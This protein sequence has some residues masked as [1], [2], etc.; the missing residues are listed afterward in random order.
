MSKR[1]EIASSG[2]DESLQGFSSDPYGSNPPTSYAL[3]VPPAIDTSVLGNAQQPR[4]WFCLATRT[5]QG[6]TTIRG[7]RQLLTIGISAPL[8]ES[9]LDYPIRCNVTTPFWRFVDGNVSWHLVSEPVTMDTNTP[10]PT[11]TYNWQKG[12]VGKGSAMLYQSFTNAAVDPVTGAPLLY[13][14]GLTAYTPPAL[15]VPRRTPIGNC[16]NLRSILYPWNNPTAWDSMCET[17]EG[18]LRVSL[19]A[20]VLPSNPQTRLSPRLPTITATGYDLGY[21][22]PE[23][24]FVAAFPVPEGPSPTSAPIYWDIGGAILFEDEG[25]SS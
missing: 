18:N 5:F 6:K 1:F 8:D 20:S 9:G 2:I 11:D 4:Y 17:L 3:R 12:P 24:T 15:A 22:V 19:Y 13:F 16:G 7:I 25:M 10:A 14:Q 23:E 21:A